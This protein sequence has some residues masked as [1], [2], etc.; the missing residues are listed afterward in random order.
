M[1]DPLQLLR[2]L[3]APRSVRGRRTPID[4]GSFS[5]LVGRARSGAM[6]SDRPVEVAPGADLASPLSDEDMAHLSAAADLAA[7]TGEERVLLMLRDRAFMLDVESRQL[8]REVFGGRGP[9]VLE[10][11]AVIRAGTDEDAPAILPP[12]AAHLPPRG[13]PNHGSRRREPNT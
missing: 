4:Q 7:S 13:I 10:I 12:P 1:I 3:A 6:R 8:E 9:R 2:R 11:G 5:D